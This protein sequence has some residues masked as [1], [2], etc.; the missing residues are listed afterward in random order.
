MNPSIDAVY[1]KPGND[2]PKAKHLSQ[3]NSS[4]RGMVAMLHSQ[5]DEIE[6]TLGGL[7]QRLECLMR[8]EPT[9]ALTTGDAIRDGDPEII[10]SLNC[11]SSK[12]SD[13]YGK[14]ETLHR[15]LAIE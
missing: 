2:I 15:T 4:L 10:S 11:L 13:I 9:K 12:L 1:L 3:A 14:I 6:G 5:A 8:E 7:S